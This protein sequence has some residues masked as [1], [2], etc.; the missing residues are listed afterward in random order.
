MFINIKGIF[1]FIDKDAMDVCVTHDSG[2][3]NEDPGEFISTA[4]SFVHIRVLYGR[5]EILDCRKKNF[6]FINSFQYTEE[7]KII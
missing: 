5:L 3:A 7:K 1:I 6:I 2:D 4:L